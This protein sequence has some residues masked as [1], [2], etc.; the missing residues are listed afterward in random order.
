MLQQC[1]HSWWLLLKS[2][3]YLSEFPNYCKLAGLKPSDFTCVTFCPFKS[4]FMSACVFGPEL[5]SWRS[6]GSVSWGHSDR[7]GR[8]SRQGSGGLDQLPVSPRSHT[9]DGILRPCRQPA[10]QLGSWTR[11]VRNLFSKAT[12]LALSRHK[13]AVLFHSFVCTPPKKSQLSTST[14]RLDCIKS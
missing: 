9:T 12:G 13:K 14:W 2:L 5:C 10:A 8:L 1:S 6:Q 3:L 4:R 7:P 11:W